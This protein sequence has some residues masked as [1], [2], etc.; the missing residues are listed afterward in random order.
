M[1]YL[2][3]RPWAS[4]SRHSSARGPGEWEPS[5]TAEVLEAQCSLFSVRLFGEVHLASQKS[6][7]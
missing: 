6:V 3:A 5:Q 4:G 7:D 1:E 2:H